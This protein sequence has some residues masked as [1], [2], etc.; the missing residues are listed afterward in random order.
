VVFGGLPGTGKISIAREVARLTG[1][2]YL[3]IDSIEHALRKAGTSAEM[4]RDQGYRVAYAVAKDNLALGNPVIADSVNPIEETR[5]AWRKVA[6]GASAS[7]L[8][9]E[10]IC[11]D[12]EEHRRR[13]EERSGDIPGLRLPTWEE[14]LARRFEPWYGE[15]LV[16]DTAVLSLDEGVRRVIAAIELAGN[17]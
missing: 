15:H 6:A 9:V 13:I 10:V 17:S 3:R 5:E 8:E 1:A 16:L 2:F 14:V 7:I 11:P 12:R 4:L